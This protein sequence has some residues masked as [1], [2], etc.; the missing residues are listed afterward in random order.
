MIFLQANNDPNVVA[1]RFLDGLQ[2]GQYQLGLDKLKELDATVTMV[3][4]FVRNRMNNHA[5]INALPPELLA[6]IFQ[7]NLPPPDAYLQFDAKGTR[8][9]VWNEVKS[10]IT[11][12]HVCRRWRA[13]ALDLGC[14][15]NL[16]DEGSSEATSAFLAR[17]NTAPLQAHITYAANRLVGVDLIPQSKNIRNLFLTISQNDRSTIPSGNPEFVFNAP[18]VECLSLTTKCSPYDDRRPLIDLHSPCEL[19]SQ[20]LPRLRRLM[21]RNMCWIPAAPYEQLTHLF[22]TEGTSIPLVALLGF[23]GRCSALE[24]LVL[25]DVYIASSSAVPHDHRVALPR[26]NRLTLGI[27]G[28]LLSMRR[29]LQY[30]VLPPT[31]TLRVMGSKAFHALSHLQP[32]PELAFTKGLDRLSVDFAPHAHAD[33]GG[34]TGNAGT[35]GVVIRASGSPSEGGAGPGLLLDF[36]TYRGTAQEAE[37]LEQ[38]MRSLIPFERLVEVRYRVCRGQKPLHLLGEGC[39]PALRVFRLVDVTQA[40]SA[41]EEEA[42]RKALVDGVAQCLRGCSGLEQLEIWNRLAAHLQEG[43]GDGWQCQQPTLLGEAFL[44]EH[45]TDVRVRAET[46]APSMKIAGTEV[47]WVERPYEW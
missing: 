12:T 11:L 26:L 10:R 1:E 31:A 38:L 45:R 42:A 44:R 37:S 41:E 18:N 4:A 17:A 47:D 28:A 23:L 46:C 27:G 20:G 39:M 36:P 34:R 24:T 5:S 7:Y 16:I 15:W 14:L 22:I 19:F 32:F 9:Q 8:V 30:V 21:L 25:V 13:V 6:L 40:G 43:V 35:G 33:A 29:V 3:L 2:R